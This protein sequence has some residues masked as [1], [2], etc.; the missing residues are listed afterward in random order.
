[1]VAKMLYTFDEARAT[2]NNGRRS[3]LLMPEFEVK[4]ITEPEW[5]ELRAEART[6]GL[7]LELDDD[8]DMI[9]VKR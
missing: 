5:H 7:E 2:I 4:E 8:G 6:H 1:M 3:A 9:A